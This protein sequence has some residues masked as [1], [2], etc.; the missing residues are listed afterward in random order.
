MTMNTPLT[1]DEIQAIQAAIFQGRKI[2]AIKIYRKA[3]VVDLKDAKDAVDQMEAELRASSPE[4]FSAKSG[5]KGCTGVLVLLC[6]VVI[7]GCW[8]TL[9]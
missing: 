2:E 8:V 1:D 9:I 3:M 4:K 6:L 7:W 5:G